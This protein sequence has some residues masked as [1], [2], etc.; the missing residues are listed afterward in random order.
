[1]LFLGVG[2]YVKGQENVRAKQNIRKKD[3]FF[4]ILADG[5]NQ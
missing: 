2:K 5:K 4:Y 3:E 1:M